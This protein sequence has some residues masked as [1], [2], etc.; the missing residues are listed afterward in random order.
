MKL[1]N[2]ISALQVSVSN[3]RDR[4]E[5]H[6]NKE[7]ARIT[8]VVMEDETVRVE[9]SGKLSGAVLKGKITRAIFLTYGRHYK[10]ERFH[11]A[12]RLR[13][14]FEKDHPE[15]VTKNEKES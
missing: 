9:M 8:A 4:N 14:Q 1:R 6:S 3:D 12:E 15:L 2:E 7:I 10:R 13:E 11:E 5:K